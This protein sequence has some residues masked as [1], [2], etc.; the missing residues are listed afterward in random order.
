MVRFRA[1]RLGKAGKVSYVV[2]WFVAERF[3]M[4]GKVCCVGMG[5]G[6]VGLGKAWYR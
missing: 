4:A 5:S 1:A 2:L 6:Y 3:G